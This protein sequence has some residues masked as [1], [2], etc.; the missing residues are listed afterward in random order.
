M[1]K[2]FTTA[3]LLPLSFLALNV[4]AGQSFDLQEIK[5]IATGWGAEGI[6]ID[7]VVTSNTAGGCGGRFMIEP[8]HPMMKEMLTIAL[9]AYHTGSKVN[10]YVDGCVNTATMN[11]KSV[12]VTK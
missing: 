10:L 7:T 12:A 2:F 5:Y 9:S 4:N 1:K 3:V 6:F 8:N 11:L